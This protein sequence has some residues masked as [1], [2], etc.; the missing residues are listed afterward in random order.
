MERSEPLL[1]N[2]INPKLIP[3]LN[4]AVAEKASEHEQFIISFLGTEQE[5]VS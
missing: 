2:S 1:V 3:Q 4:E 5:A